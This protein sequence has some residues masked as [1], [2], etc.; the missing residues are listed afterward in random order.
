MVELGVIARRQGSGSVVISAAPPATYTQSI[1]S[2]SDLFQ[3]ALETHFTKLSTRFVMPNPAIQSAIGGV[4]GERWMLMRGLR[5]DRPGGKP[6]CTIHS[7]IPDRLAWIVPELPACV[8]PFYE[9]IALRSGEPM[10]DA[11]QEITAGVMTGSVARAL[12]RPV[13]STTVRVLRRYRSAQGILITSLNWHPAD[14]FVFRTHIQRSG[15]HD[16][17]SSSNG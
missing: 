11:V 8:G 10:I 9:H 1:R 4:P 17:S 14:D 5:R 2:L 6:L 16:A 13:G 3:L 7:Y 15:T 12:G